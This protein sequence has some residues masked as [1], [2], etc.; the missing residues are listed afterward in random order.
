MIAPRWLTVLVLIGLLVALTMNWW[1][2]W[3]LL[4]LFW[5]VP[6]IRMGEVHLIGTI[7]RDQQPILFWIV[8]VLWVLL[9]V[10][11]ILVDAA[12]SVINGF[13]A[14]MWGL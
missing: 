14:W 2:P 6:A 5:T 7:P 8:T 10:A 12:P 4:F 9:G 3:G 1:W 11:M 13:Y